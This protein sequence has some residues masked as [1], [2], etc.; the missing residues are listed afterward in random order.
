MTRKSLDTVRMVKDIDTEIAH[1]S[2]EIAGV[3]ASAG[4]KIGDID[5]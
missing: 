2:R 4:L 1:L 3:M 5:V